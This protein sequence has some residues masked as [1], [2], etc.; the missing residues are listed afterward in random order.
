MA[1]DGDDLA[2]IGRVLRFVNRN[3]THDGASARNYSDG[4]I[5]MYQQAKADGTG[6]N[7][8][9]MAKLTNQL[10]LALGYKSRYVTCMPRRYINDCHV[11][12]AVWVPS[13][14]GWLYADPMYGTFVYD[15]TGRPLTLPQVRSGLIDGTPMRLDEDATYNGRTVSIEDAADYLNRYMTKNLYYMVV[16]LDAHYAPEQGHE[17]FV[18]LTPTGFDDTR[19]GSD[20]VI[21]NDDTYFWQSPQNQPQ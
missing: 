4:A 7:C 3:T 9:Y 10:L 11:I 5:E 6:L 18:A 21:T 13:V 12:N 2:R 14:G 17:T 8:R 15:M 16:P 19:T 20:C 1:G